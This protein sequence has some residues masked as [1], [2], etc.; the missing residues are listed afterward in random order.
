VSLG[1]AIGRKKTDFVGRR[2]LA[3]PA[4]V[5][6]SRLQLVALQPVD[7]ETWLPVGGQI[8]PT[9]PPGVSEG[10]VTSSALS[11]E[12]GY[13]SRSRCCEVDDS[14]PGNASAFIISA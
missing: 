5:D 6:P 9:S 7:R 13:P 14:E 2:S 11:P 3:R 1:G 12:L 8:A 10:H 4:A